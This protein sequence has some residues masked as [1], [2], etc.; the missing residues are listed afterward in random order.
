ML[1]SALFFTILLL[2]N[3]LFGQQ[4]VYWQQK[5]DYKIKVDFDD[6]KHQYEGEEWITYTNLSPD[7]LNRL[8]FHLY[9]N[10]FQPNSMMDVRLRSIVDPDRRVGDRISKLDKDD[11]VHAHHR[12]RNGWQEAQ[13]Y[14]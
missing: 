11:W 8:F 12:N 9:Y 13:E 1:R 3:N 7:T 5:A 6:K 14:P 4:N 10:A 2:V